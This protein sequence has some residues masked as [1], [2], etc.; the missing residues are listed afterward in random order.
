MQQRAM[1]IARQQQLTW[2]LGRC[3]QASLQQPTGAINAI[4]TALSA[5]GLG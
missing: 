1:Q 3:Q 4:P 5:K 2:P